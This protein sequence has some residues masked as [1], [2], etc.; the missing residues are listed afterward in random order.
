MHWT[1][2]DMRRHVLGVLAVLLLVT[3]V[4]G[5][6]T[7]GMKESQANVLFSTCERIGLVFGAAWLAYPQLVRLGTRVSARFA[8]MMVAIGLIILVR[9]RSVILLGPVML[10]LAALQFAG[11]L[12]KPPPRATGSPRQLPAAPLEQSAQKT[13]R[14]ST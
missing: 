13:N 11:W 5:W 6:S 12:M 8:L 4:Y 14:E 3:A 2:S 7:Y 10:V 9:P 1:E